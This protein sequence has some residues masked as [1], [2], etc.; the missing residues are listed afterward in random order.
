MKRI[1]IFGFIFFIL[2]ACGGG[3][4]DNPYPLQ[5]PTGVWIGNYSVMSPEV[6]RSWDLKGVVL[7][8]RWMLFH[9]DYLYYS[10]SDNLYEGTPIVTEQFFDGDFR[11][12]WNNSFDS[13]KYYDGIVFTKDHIYGS[14]ES[15]DWDLSQFSMYYSDLTERGASL[16]ILESNWSETKSSITTTLSIDSTGII[17]GSDTNGCIYNGTIQAPNTNKNIYKIEVNLSM[18]DELDGDYS[19]LGF[20]SGATNDLFQ[21][22]ISNLDHFINLTIK[23]V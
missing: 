20:T 6:K 18:C 7:E 5:D 11:T 8:G 9:D 14:T 12:Y 3:G 4:D 1:L 23:R 2:T 13:N 19:G 21:F 15:D 10:S 17:H 16:T 22:S